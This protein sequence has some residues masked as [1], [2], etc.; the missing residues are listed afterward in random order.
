MPK[1]RPYYRNISGISI[2]EEAV[3]HRVS[4]II[5]TVGLTMLIRKGH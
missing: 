4:Y 3:R 1:P 2:E 5:A